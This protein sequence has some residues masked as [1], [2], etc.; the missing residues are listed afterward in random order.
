MRF[1]MVN[2]GGYDVRLGLIQVGAE[3]SGV[4]DGRGW[5]GM[6]FARVLE[7]FW[8]LGAFLGP[9]LLRLLLRPPLHL[10]IQSRNPYIFMQNR[11]LKQGDLRT[12]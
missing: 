4:G 7:G 11:G 5:S 12:T 2:S 10:L 8:A 1:E 6:L 3:G 9:L